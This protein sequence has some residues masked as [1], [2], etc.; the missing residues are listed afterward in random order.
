MHRFFLASSLFTVLMAFATPAQAQIAGCKMTTGGSTGIVD[1]DK[2]PTLPVGATRTEVRGSALAPVEIR[3]G[4]LLLIAREIDY[5]KP[6][7]RFFARGDVVYQ[8]GGT[9]ITADS[10]EFDRKTKLGSFEK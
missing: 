10:G 4:E 1:H 5:L 3:C 2:D 9:R 8:Q 6:E 7:E